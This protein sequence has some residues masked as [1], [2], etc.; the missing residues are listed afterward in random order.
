MVIRPA[1][2]GSSAAEGYDRGLPSPGV[3]DQREFPG[4]GGT[5]RPSAQLLRC[6][7]INSPAL[8]ATRL[9]LPVRP[10]RPTA[11]PVRP[12][13]RTQT[14]PP[15]TSPRPERRRRGRGA[16]GSG[17]VTSSSSKPK[18][19]SEDAMAL[20]QLLPEIPRRLE[21][22]S[23]LNESGQHPD[24]EPVP[25]ARVRHAERA[26]SAAP[27]GVRWPGRTGRH[28][29]GAEGLEMLLIDGAKPCARRPRAP[30]QLN[31]RMEVVPQVTLLSRAGGAGCAKGGAG[32]LAEVGGDPSNG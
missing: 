29:D 17:T 15:R 20:W 2:A 5:T 32:A 14:T 23:Q 21:P 25:A 9:A 10:D 24:G 19:R 31:D 3:P 28:R 12:V 18:I 22:P 1:A 27:S 26:A 16:V 4:A 11:S 13:R 6:S 30:E 7:G 8:S